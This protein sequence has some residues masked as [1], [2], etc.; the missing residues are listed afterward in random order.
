[1]NGR[2]GPG[3]QQDLQREQRAEF[4]SSCKETVVSVGYSGDSAHMA[5]H[6]PGQQGQQKYPSA[7]YHQSHQSDKSVLKKVN[8]KLFF[9]LGVWPQLPAAGHLPWLSAKIKPILQHLLEVDKIIF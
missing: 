2:G 3:L 5:S 6:D 9:A 4:C 7:Q 8:R 1:M